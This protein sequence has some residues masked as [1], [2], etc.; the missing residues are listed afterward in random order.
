[1]YSL[2]SLANR[3]TTHFCFISSIPLYAHEFIS[4]QWYL[5]YHLCK[6][7]LF[8]DYIVGSASTLCI[9]VI[10]YDRYQ[11]VSEGLSYFSSITIRRALKFMLGTWIIAILNYGKDALVSS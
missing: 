6:F 9:V 10:S 7:W 4:G 8:F 5:G 11:M 3:S 2:A 1:M